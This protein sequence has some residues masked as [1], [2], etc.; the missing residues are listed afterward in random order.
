MKY[1]K[2]E[3]SNWVVSLEQTAQNNGFDYLALGPA[4]PEKKDSFELVPQIMQTTRNV[5]LCG[6][7]VTQKG[8]VSLPAVHACAT[9][10][11]ELSTLHQMASKSQFFC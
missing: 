11:H 6:N 7:M 9:I 2:K 4:L 10:I 5:F 3:F 1:P 8:E